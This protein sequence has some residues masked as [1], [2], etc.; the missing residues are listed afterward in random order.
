MKNSAKFLLV[1]SCFVALPAWAVPTQLSHMGWIADSTGVPLEGIQ[2]MEFAVYDDPMAGNAVWSDSAVAVSFSGGFYSVVLGSTTNPIDSSVVAGDSLYLSVAL[3]GSPEF[4]PRQPL[5]S[6]PFAL[7]AETADNLASTVPA[8]VNLNCAT[9]SFPRWDGSNW[10]CVAAAGSCAANQAVIGRNADGTVACGN[11][12][13]GITGGNNISA[14]VSAAGVAT[15]NFVA[16]NSAAQ[17]YVQAPNNGSKSITASSRY[18][19]CAL[20]WVDLGAAGRCRI[21]RN[22]ANEWVLTATSYQANEWIN[23]DMWC[24]NLGF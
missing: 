13:T 11:V 1:F 16:T 18:E 4:S 22:A 7:R 23:C 3:T 15:L 2:S 12:I 9:D 20:G 5:T 24:L 17:F 14:T 19:Y 10:V 21:T 8:L 6:V